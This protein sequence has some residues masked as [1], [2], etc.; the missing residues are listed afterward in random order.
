[1]STPY[2]Y[3][4]PHLAAVL[5]LALATSSC[6]TLGL[7]GGVPEPEPL[8]LAATAR[9]MAELPPRLG[10][11]GGELRLPSG[12]VNARGTVRALIF[13]VTV[14]ERLPVWTDSMIAYD[15]VGTHR[16]PNERAAAGFLVG[17]SNGLFRLE[18]SIFPHLVDAATSP[19]AISSEVLTP[20]GVQALV[21][22]AIRTWASR[23]NLAAYDNDGPDGHPMS[24]DDDGILDLPIVVLETDST[25]AIARVPTRIVLPAGR[26]GRLQVRAGTVQLIAVPRRSG[27]E[28]QDMGLVAAVLGATGLAAEEMF[29]PA[30]FDRQIS[31]LA[32][33]RLGWVGGRLAAHSGEYAVEAGVAIAV[34][35]VDV[36]TN[37]GLWLIERDGD[38]VYLTRVARKSDG[39]FATI[40]ARQVRE[41]DPEIL[42]PLTAS[43][44]EYGARLRVHWAAGEPAKVVVA[45]TEAAVRADR[46]RTEGAQ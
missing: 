44:G 42:V 38:A 13:P 40:D 37:R 41:G 24:G 33:L 14:G 26:D 25:P 17:A 29:F 3:T 20:A 16:P 27:A 35:L 28:P 31:T 30:D 36:D 39:H 34:P 7:A 15:L 4:A 8:S 32:R 10:L 6:G 2:R 46:K 12:S 45:L 5:A 1:M 22:R 19:E 18:A 9:T 11:G 21:E 23:V 43:E